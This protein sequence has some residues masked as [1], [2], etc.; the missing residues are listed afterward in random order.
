M[1]RIEEGRSL[2]RRWEESKPTNFYEDDQHL[3]R[4][5]AFRVDAARLAPVAP[6]LHQAGADAAGPVSRASA[7][8]DRPEHLPR[9]EPWNGIGERTE[10]IVFH[11]A[12]HEVGRLVWRSRVLSLLGEPGNV[13]L[14]TA[15]AYLFAQ[16]GEVPHLCPVAC[17]SGLIKAIQRCGSDWM[18]REWLPRLLDPD[19]DRR[20][21]GAQFLTEVQGGSDVGANAC[22][23]R[24]VRETPGAWRISG[25]KWF[26]S[27]VHADL[28]AVS[29]RPEGAPEGTKGIG[30]FVV[31]RR[32]DDGRPNG[33][34]I[35]RLK[36]KLGTR[37]LPTAEV[38]FQDALGYQLGSPEEGFRVMMGVIINTSRLGVALGSCGIMRRAWVEALHYARAREAF[39]R[40][41]IEF[42]AVRE[43][44]AEMRALSVAGLSSTLFLAALEDRLTLEGTHPEDDPLFRIGVNINKYI[45]SVDGGLVVHHGIEILGGNGTIEDFS[46]LPRLYREMPVEESWEGPHNT[47]MAQILR[48][49]LKSKMHDALLGRA[50]DTLLGVK[51]PALAATR[52]AATAGLQD[53]REKL[54]RLL[55]RDPEAAAL[56]VR[57]LVH[58]M[59]RIFQASLLLEEADQDLTANRPTRLPEIARFFVSRY[60]EP[61]YD[62]AEDPG[63]GDLIRQIVE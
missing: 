37:T 35:R 23:A 32:L 29:A 56:G 10:E 54:H 53:G 49:A 36:Q 60:V 28:Y 30:L 27:N 52:E 20:W 41:L 39:G 44:L 8:L 24:P 31:P 11:P 61:G 6:L 47:M 19:Y 26:C 7:L 14:H 59:A 43:Q 38:D 55:R 17:T 48:D 1:N 18:R 3:R 15:L 21:H 58:R 22:V 51:H 13:A 40:R 34:F 46:P 45:C 12:Y 2:L 62:P 33:V 63:Y 16:N 25:E 42:P 4:V 5:L 57:R 9:L 50:E